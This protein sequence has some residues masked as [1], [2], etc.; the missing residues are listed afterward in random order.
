[1]NTPTTAPAQDLLSHT[2]AFCDDCL[3]RED[4]TAAWQALCRAVDL[5]PNRADVLSHRGRLALF[6][7]DTETARRDFAEALKNDPR[8][9]AALSGLARY[10]W[11]QGEA[12]EAEAAADRALSIDPADEEAAQV[13]VEIQAQR[14]SKPGNGKLNT[15]QEYFSCSHL[16]A[17]LNFF[18][19]KLTHCCYVHG[20]GRG[21][22]PITPYSGG[23]LPIEQI[24]EARQRLIV[25]IN[26]GKDTRCSG[27]PS[28]KKAKWPTG[29]PLFKFLQFNHGYQCNLRCTYCYLVRNHQRM[30]QFYD[31]YPVVQDMIQRGWL[32]AKPHITWGGGEPTMMEHFND[33][34]ALLCERGASHMMHTNGIAFSDSIYN[35]LGKNNITIMTSIDA[36]TPEVFARLRGRDKMQQLIENLTRYHAKHPACLQ[37][38]YIITNENCTQN[39]L[40]AFVELLRHHKFQGAKVILDIDAN[41]A[42]E[43]RYITALACWHH[44]L[45]RDYDVSFSTMTQTRVPVDLQRL[46]QTIHN[47]GLISLYEKYDRLLSAQN[48]V[49]DKS[50]EGASCMK[51]QAEVLYG[52][53]FYP[54][55]MDW[56]WM[57]Q[58]GEC[59]LSLSRSSEVEFVL[60]CSMIECYPVQPFEVSIWAGKEL[61]W[62]SLFRSSCQEQLVRFTIENPRP[63]TCVRLASQAVM[64]PK[65]HNLSNDTRRLSVR[66][67]R[68][69]IHSLPGS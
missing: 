63:I 36:G 56:H 16:E 4:Y 22:P 58:E 46:C 20:E 35:Y 17:G 27:C 49:V 15:E 42:L 12:V 61:K 3:S 28:L 60:Q 10:Q 19:D 45:Y 51:Q 52:S 13:K 1:M 38:K 29:E 43:N 26:A 40:D 69:A 2:L 7:K 53:G 64:I 50:L 6:L 55:E 48:P 41:A 21:V 33:V 8:C 9:S 37:L 59:F 47:H 31:I 14:R 18:P 67:G 30:A 66:L 11:Q 54:G 23:P 57:D 62:K 32:A 39:E 25:D 44:A 68:L 24:Q 5:A 65:E 34:F